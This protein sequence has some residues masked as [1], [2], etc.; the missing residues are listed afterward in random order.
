MRLDY[1]P[2][3]EMFC[4]YVRPGEE[5]GPNTLMQDYGL[6]LSTSASNGRETCL[7]TATPYAAASFA[8]YATPAA[9]QQLGWLIREIESS[10]ALSSDMHFD[11]PRA[12]LD[13]GIDLW[14]YQKADL[15]YMLY[16][17]RVLDADEPGLGKTPTAIVYANE[18]QAQRVLVICPASI[19]FQWAGKIAGTRSQPGWS[20]MGQTYDVPNTTVEVVTT[21]RR[22]VHPKAAWTIVSYELARDPG[23]LAALRQSKYDLLILDEAHYLK[24]VGSRRTRAVFGGGHDPLYH[25]ALADQS[26]RVVALSGT[27]LPN[28]PREAYVLARNFDHASIDYMSEERFGDAFNPIEMRDVQKRDG[29]WVKIADESSGRHA[30]LQNRMRA[31]FMTRHLKREVLTQLKYPVYNLVEVEET[32]PIRA[33]LKAESLLGFDV[34]ELEARPEHMTWG[35]VIGHIAEARRIMG[36][37]MAPQVAKYVEMCLDGGEEK[38]TLFYWHISVGAILQKH[39]DK[40]GVCRVDGNTGAMAKEALV[41][42]FQTDPRYRVMMGNTLS[43]GTGTDGLQ[44]VCYHGIIAEPD[45]VPG[46]NIQ[47]FDRLDRGGQKM[48][49]QGD[50]CVV[51]GSLAEKV[52]SKA[53]RKLRTTHAALDRRVA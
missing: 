21:A 5:P 50:I 53:L 7:F 42:R 6:S 33:A 34:D 32:A 37:A 40:Y 26:K 20:T 38:I 8:Q 41:E 39:L 30:E 43:L 12:L 27:P 23:I 4:L 49:V 45:W 25:E 29:T 11:V 9:M 22:G 44:H 17:D 36:E 14:D 28:R 52:L 48:L 31:H 24:N 35:Q 13:E 16:R 47:C 51:P 3:T 1:S 2:Q 19:R 18:I 15:E 46:N 10:R